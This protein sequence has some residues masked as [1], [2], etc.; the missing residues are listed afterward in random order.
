MTDGTRG[1]ENRT[2]NPGMATAAAAMHWQGSWFPSCQGLPPL[3]A[4]AC[5]A[6]VHG[7]A[8]DLLAVP[9][10]PVWPYSLEIWWRPYP[11]F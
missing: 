8:G 1:Y 10:G 11:G 3:E 4:A 2:G 7:A 6:W 5:A 9:G